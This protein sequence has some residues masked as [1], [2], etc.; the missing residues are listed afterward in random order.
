M[1]I[2]TYNKIMEKWEGL[3][4]QDKEPF[5]QMYREFGDKLISGQIQLTER[6]ERIPRRLPDPIKQPKV[7]RFSKGP[8]SKRGMTAL[9]A[10][11]AQTGRQDRL[12]KRARRD[13][14][15]E[16]RN[17]AEA[18]DE[19]EFRA[20]ELDLLQE[21]RAKSKELAGGCGGGCWRC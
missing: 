5:A 7:A 13:R 11:E 2:D 6:N 20:L 19:A 1:M 21:K 4:A 18:E 14:A 16:A 3:D 15:I 17:A 9:E 8:K 12:A 10:A